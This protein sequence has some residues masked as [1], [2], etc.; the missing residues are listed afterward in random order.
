LVPA[1]VK[2]LERPPALPPSHLIDPAA[3]TSAYNFKEGFHRA[4]WDIVRH[5]IQS[6]I[7]PLD[8]SQA[9]SEAALHWV[10]QL[11]DDVGAGY[12]VLQSEQAILLSDLPLPTARWVLDYAGRAG[13]TIKAHLKGVAW[14]GATS[15][16]VILIFSEEDDYYQYLAYYLK[17]GVQPQSGGMCINSGYTHIVIPWH[18]ELEAANV[19][20][21]ELTH[22]SLAH[23]ALPCW[24]NEGVAVVLEKAVAPSPPYAG[25]SE[26]SALY[27]AAINWRAPV[28]WDELAERHFAFWNE[29]NIQRFWA[30][31]SF[32]EPGD[33]NQLS[34]SLAQVLVTL[35][36]ERGSS[37][38]DF[39][40]RAR[41]DD[42]GQTAALDILG[43]DLGDVA[44]TFLGEGNWRPRRKV[45]AD[46]WKTEGW[47][48]C[49][50]AKSSSS[51]E[52][53]T[54]P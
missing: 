38:L 11:R 46:I 17:E 36:N 2:E 52:G 47:T 25:Q 44:A 13:D 22:D 7:S 23:L 54:K 31:T 27:S 45:I 39:L 1:Q 32:Y 51:Q 12:Y 5:W 20:V 29:D 41:F 33:S 6:N 8:Q 50:T 15:K 19:I 18:D 24:L 35:L 3:V 49:S 4:D 40:E 9:W 53:N 21:H 42:A 16:D 26:Q 43:I 10:S 30:G 37:F 48:D 34:Y 28:M 14:A